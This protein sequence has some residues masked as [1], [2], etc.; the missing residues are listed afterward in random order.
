MPGTYADLSL[1]PRFQDGRRE[2]I[3]ESCPLTSTWG[4]H[5]YAHA[6]A[7]TSKTRG[8]T[9]IYMK[10]SGKVISISY[11]NKVIQ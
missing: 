2:T 11:I 9:D 1:M 4:A 6:H 7:L 10:E 8:K 5:A 3:P